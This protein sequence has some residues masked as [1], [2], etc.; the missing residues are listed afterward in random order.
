MNAERVKQKLK[1]LKRLGGKNLNN[2]KELL[3]AYNF[4]MV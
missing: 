2:L 1:K 3:K 4:S